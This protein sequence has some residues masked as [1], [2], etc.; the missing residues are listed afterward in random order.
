MTN[1]KDNYF[2]LIFGIILIILLLL[3][4]SFC[5]LGTKAEAKVVNYST[6]PIIDGENDVGNMDIDITII[7]RT[8]QLINISFKSNFAGYFELYIDVDNDDSPDYLVY[9]TSLYVLKRIS[10]QKFWDGTGWGGV[11]TTIVMVQTSYIEV[12]IPIGA[13]ILTA[14]DEYAVRAYNIWGEDWAPNITILPVFFL[15][16]IE[17]SITGLSVG[18]ANAISGTLIYKNLDDP[19]WSKKK[20]AGLFLTIIT[21]SIIVCLILFWFIP[22]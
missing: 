20:K 8:G 12:D 16:T 21:S 19:P 4:I 5:L 1:K 18:I 14:A 6:A 17:L 2:S 11:P 22:L 15:S 10:D 13:F 3:P 9:Y 7:E